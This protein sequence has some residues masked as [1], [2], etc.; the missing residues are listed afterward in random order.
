M[1]CAPESVFIGRIDNLGLLII[2]PGLM[3]KNVGY[4]YLYI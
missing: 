4:K 3:I 1:L 2:Q